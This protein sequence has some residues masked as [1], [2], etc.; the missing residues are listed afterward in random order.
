MSDRI[1]QTEFTENTHQPLSTPVV[2]SVPIVVSPTKSKVPLF[3]TIAIVLV[4]VLGSITYIGMNSNR[5]VKT[6]STPTPTPSEV[7]VET[8]S[9]RS[10]I[11]P[12]FKVIEDSNPEADEHPFPPVNFELRIKDPAAR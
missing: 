3:A 8:K 12:Y 6:T 7:P 10:E 11:A 1:N 2:P 9:I 4:V 5:S